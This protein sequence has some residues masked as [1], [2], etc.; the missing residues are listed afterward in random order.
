MSLKSNNRFHYEYDMALTRDDFL[1]L[2]P[3]AVAHAPYR[4]DGDE[5]SG[6]DAKLA[7]HI[8]LEPRPV[9]RI[10][11]LALPALDVKIVIDT[12]SSEAAKHFIE[13][14]LLGFQRAGG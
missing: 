6:N 9:R 8:T 4:I 2:L 11:L 7:W 12:A 13:R 14:F 5:I 10:A 3:V 1:R